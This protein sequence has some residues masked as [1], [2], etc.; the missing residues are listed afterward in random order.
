MGSGRRLTGTR[1]RSWRGSLAALPVTA[2]AG[3]CQVAHAEP[4]PTAVRWDAPAECPTIHDVEA[5]L[6]DA[7]W[8]SRTTPPEATVR[9]DGAGYRLDLALTGFD[10]GRRERTLRTATCALAVDAL[11]VV[12]VASSVDTKS[13]RV[14]EEPASGLPAEAPA[15]P[16]LHRPV[17]T[18]IE[19]GARGIGDVG[20]LPSV[21]LGGGGELGLG[22]GHFRFALRGGVL[23][24]ASASTSG[25]SRGEFMAVVSGLAAC[26]APL[27]GV[28][29]RAGAALS[30]CVG[31]GAAFVEGRGVAVESARSETRVVPTIDAGVE[32]RFPAESTIA[33]RIGLGLRV[34]LVR[35]DFSVRNDASLHRPSAI[36]GQIAVGP[37]VRF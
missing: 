6:R 30:G 7:E 13:A 20:L 36:G 35:P 2:V 26:V 29:S 34:P 31:L 4:S 27:D 14:T 3:V 32:A 5:R 22:I 16:P 15:Q 33:L 17:R 23:A 1:R 28:R 8:T 11:V 9:A 25:G 12:L 24:P 10:G 37:E 21:T 19:V 18:S